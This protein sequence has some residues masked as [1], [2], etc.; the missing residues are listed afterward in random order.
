MTASPGFNNPAY[1]VGQFGTP[2]WGVAGVL[3]FTGNY[4]WVDE[5]SGSDGNTGGPS[6]PFATLS[7]ALSKCTS[8]NNDVVFL[9]GT[10]H[11]SAAVAWNKSRTHLIG[12]APTLRGNARA[13]ISQTGSSVFTPLVN[14]TGSECIFMNIGAFHGFANASA[15][16]CWT[17]AGQRNYYKNCA[18]LGMGNATAAAQAGG[19]SLLISSAGG[20]EHNFVECQIGL[21]TITRSAANASLELAGGTPRN[22][23]SR[24]IL[25]CLTSSATALFIKTSGAAAI[26]RDQVFED[27]S[28]INQIQ[29]TSTQMTVAVSMSASAGGLLEMKSCTLIGATKWGD[30]AALAQM[31]VDGGAPTA[32]TTGIAVN[33]S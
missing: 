8:N 32:A 24:C 26:D 31:Y 1:L 13:R 4:F 12:L 28:F 25:P 16:I 11:V 20:G 29:S 33:P 27:C 9:T 14:V 21:D 15:Q 23:F 2:I 30:T 6:D 18:F 5:N 19:R 17:E 3:P 10:V 7:Q 22:V